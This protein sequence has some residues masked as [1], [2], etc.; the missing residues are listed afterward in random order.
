MRKG[1]ERGRRGIAAILAI[2]MLGVLVTLGVSY[3]MLTNGAMR[4]A[5]NF[6]DAQGA[7]LVA[8][9]GMSFMIHKMRN[10]GVS[11]SLRGQLLLDSLA[12]KLG[13]KADGSGRLNG[14]VVSYDST[15]ISVS[16]IPLDNGRTFSFRITL[17]APDKLRLVVTGQE[18]SGVGDSAIAI[19]RRLAIE[20]LPTWDETLGYGLC[21]KG[22]VELGHNTELAGVT[23]LS[24]GSIYSAA[25]GVAVGCAS[26]YIS[27]SISLSNPNASVALGGTSLG[28]QIHYNAP[29]VVMPT[30]DRQPYIDLATNTLPAG[31]SFSGTF[32]NLRIPANRNPSFGDVTIQG[33]LYVE[34]PNR[35]FFNNNVNFTGVMVAAD[36]AAGSTDYQ[37]YIY[38]KNNMT[39]RGAE[40]LPDT[41]EFTPVKTLLNI[42]A[43]TT[44]VKGGVSI[45]CPDFEMEFKNNMSSV[46]GIMAVKTLTAKNNLSST[47]YGS[48]LIYGDGGLDF[49]NN[50]D[51]RISLSNSQPPPGFGGHG[52]APLE[53]DP[54]TYDELAED[55]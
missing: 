53:P 19:D 30:I 5:A 11:G 15:A 39:F 12:A 25:T 14:E 46:G 8:D 26:G 7:M 3:A 31:T 45:L 22:P 47:V 34:S 10:C 36:Q 24:D 18:I 37:N 54:D 29:E 43:G 48:L 4:Q 6:A 32:K 33:V 17:A 50:S 44:E 35:I 20:L 38:F 28:G 52:L 16:G 9:S 13:W 49:K 42:P 1:T 27:G 41:A 51:L 40:Y 23:I 55:D 2:I 21:C